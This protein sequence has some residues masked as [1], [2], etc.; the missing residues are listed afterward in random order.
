MSTDV[1]EKSYLAHEA[2]DIDD[3]IE[4]VRTAR[5]T[6][7]N[8]DARLDGIDTTISGIQ[9]D[10]GTNDA[11]VVE[12]VNIGAKNR[13]T[14]NSGSA[15]L[16]TS[17]PVNLPAGDYVISIGEITSTDTDASVCLL[18]L[19]DSSSN[20][21]WSGGTT[22]G[23]GKEIEVTISGAAASFMIYAS[24]NYS[25]SSGDTVT[26]SNLMICTQTDYDVSETYTEYCPTMA[27]MYAELNGVN[28]LVGG[29]I[30]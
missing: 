18:T 10:I 6:S 30:S 17:I 13:C 5:G 27:E 28:A 14:V 22:R 12:I 4:E 8:L 24:D 20:A 11:A 15:T 2:Q 3:T 29:G 9:S 19:I 26:F 16:R 23:Q 25:H 7:A 21:L 1:G